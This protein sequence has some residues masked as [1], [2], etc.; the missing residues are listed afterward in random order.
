MKNIYIL[1]STAVIFTI[2]YGE[3]DWK[4]VYN[5][6]NGTFMDVY[7]LSGSQ[8]GWAVGDKV[9]WRDSIGNI[10]TMLHTTDG[11][12]TW[13]PW[14]QSF[15]Q[16]D[17][18]YGIFFITE[19]EGWAVGEN[20]TISHTTDGGVNWEYQ[21]CPVGNAMLRSVCFVNPDT[22]W[23]TG[24]SHGYPAQG[25]VLKTED[26]GQNWTL[27]WTAPGGVNT[28]LLKIVFKDPLTGWVAGFNDNAGI[29]YKTIDGGQN[30]YS[31]PLPPS[32]AALPIFGLDFYD[33]QKG[34]YCTTGVGFIPY[35]T[36]G[37]A[38][39]TVVSGGTGSLM[40]IRFVD[41]LCGWAVGGDLYGNSYIVHSTDGGLN[42]GQI[43]HPTNN[44]LW[45]IDAIDTDRATAVGFHT[46]VLYTSDAGNAWNY[47]LGGTGNDAIAIDASDKDNVWVCGD[48]GFVI[49][50]S[51]GGNTWHQYEAS[52]YGPTFLKIA[53]PDNY[54]VWVAGG[55]QGSGACVY[56]TKDGGLTWQR[57]AQNIGGVTY[58]WGMDFVDTSYGWICSN[59]ANARIART[60][61]GGSNWNLVYGPISDCDLWAIDFIDR[62]TGW[63]VGDSFS[64]SPPAYHAWIRK[65]TDGGNTWVSQN[66][67]IIDMDLQ[68]VDFVN[69]QVGYITGGLFGSDQVFLKTTDGGNTW[70][71]LLPDD[72]LQS[73]FRV[74]FVNENEGWVKSGL[75]VYH[76]LNGGRDWHTDAQFFGDGFS[77][78]EDLVAFDS[79]HAYAC[80]GHGK[81]FAYRPPTGISE[82]LT[83][84]RQLWKN[85]LN[86][87]PSL[88]S[89]FTSISYAISHPSLVSLEVYNCAGQQIGIVHRGNQNSGLYQIEWQGK[90]RT[91][92]LLPSGTYFLL[93]KIG[94]HTVVSKIVKL[95]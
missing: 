7:F 95:R 63:A 48:Y 24:L 18:Y 61:D 58:W 75:Y 27:Q 8:L 22:G 21:S 92:R 86:V 53:S 11:G 25:Y 87:S 44:E 6:W 4:L 38:T 82:R 64:Y 83:T 78:W 66:P 42:W 31:L 3:N 1:L 43:S 5:A 59:G 28:Y 10:W 45:A 36:D 13:L 62:N 72:T 41:S 74:D 30:W 60:T 69:S 67:G 54:H 79:L 15:G 9:Y 20:G 50:S 52:E 35:T 32:I 29:I 84:S 85:Y 46:T 68:D 71:Y 77:N 88:F 76:T 73:V 49:H 80:H 51:D 81:V 55:F 12:Q 94:A 23:I 34:W 16:Y 93:L 65:T 19:T 40:D 2:I 89:N 90:D 33:G 14:S 17:T 56:A 39:W 26:G 70:S 47:P 91:G 57:Q 37:G